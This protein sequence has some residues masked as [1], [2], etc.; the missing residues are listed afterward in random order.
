MDPVSTKCTIESFIAKKQPTKLGVLAY[1]VAEW[2]PIFFGALSLLF[3]WQGYYL[4]SG[5]SII[6]TIV[7]PLFEINAIDPEEITKIQKLFAKLNREK[8]IAP[9]PEK[10]RINVPEFKE[11]VLWGLIELYCRHKNIEPLSLTETQL[12]KIYETYDAIHSYN[13]KP[14]E[15]PAKRFWEEPW[16]KLLRMD[17]DN[18]PV[19][20]ESTLKFL[21]TL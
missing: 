3:L 20:D 21:S 7:T 16:V 18:D 10:E 4:L 2:A 1:K 13:E 14:K 17:S 8:N 11:R 12:A 5:L 19:V 9:L 15:A 6:C